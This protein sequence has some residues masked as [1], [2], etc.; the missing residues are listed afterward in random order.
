MFSNL[1]KRATIAVRICCVAATAGV[2]L[3]ALSTYN[4]RVL[5][6]RAMDERQAKL[7]SAVETAYGVVA[8]FA[9][10]AQEGRLSREEAQSVALKTIGGLRYERNECCV[11]CPR[12]PLVA[13]RL[14][15][16]AYC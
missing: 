5:E 2:C 6:T 9:D 10:L 15:R 11:A 16:H 3:V 13:R 12:T 8:H 1:R 4:L 7:R 14:Q